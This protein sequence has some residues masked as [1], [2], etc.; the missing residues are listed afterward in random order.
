MPEARAMILAAGRGER[1]RPLTDDRPKPLLEAGGRPLIEHHLERLRD[2]G[3]REIVVNLAHLGHMIREHLNDGSRLGLSITYSDEGEALETGGGI[4]RALPLL[5]DAPFLV[6]NGD[7]WCDHPLTPP[8]FAEG[9]LAHLVLVDNPVHNPAG[10]FHLVDRRVCAHGE[11]RLTFSGIGW[12]RAELF[13]GCE[14]GRF[15]LAP[16][17]RQAMADDRVSGEHH[18]GGWLDVGTPQRLAALDRMLRG[19]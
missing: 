8:V 16:L 18:F 17:L 2:A 7:I 5:G 13:E 3:Y 15:P 12:Y 6:I 11:P 9:D 10:D 4:L 19:A 1:M 14:P